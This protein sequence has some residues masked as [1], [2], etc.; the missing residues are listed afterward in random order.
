[1]SK[2]PS[3]TQRDKCQALNRMT[4]KNICTLTPRKPYVKT[5]KCQQSDFG[6][7]CRGEI[8]FLFLI[9]RGLGGA[10]EAFLLP[11]TSQH[12]NANLFI[13]SEVCAASEGGRGPFSFSTARSQ[14]LTLE[15][16]RDPALSQPRGGWNRSQIQ[17]PRMLYTEGH[18]IRSLETEGGG[19][20]VVPM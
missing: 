16:H 6:R 13:S 14:E 3:F 12:I 19:R 5:T 11:L 20:E 7:Q 18:G 1:M 9:F 2:T 17:R 8:L 10:N 15:D 4:C